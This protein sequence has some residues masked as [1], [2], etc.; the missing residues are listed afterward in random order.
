METR[1]WAATCTVHASGVGIEANRHFLLTVGIDCNVGLVPNVVFV[2][3]DERTFV[4]IVVEGHGDFCNVTLIFVH[5][6]LSET[7]IAFAP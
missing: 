6:S 2:T 3:D 5:D 7:D 4:D 1:Y